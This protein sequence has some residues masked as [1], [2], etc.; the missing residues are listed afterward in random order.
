[1]LN[2]IGRNRVVLLKGFI[3]EL[4]KQAQENK[5]KRK[6]DKKKGHKLTKNKRLVELYRVG[7][8]G[9]ALSSSQGQQKF[10]K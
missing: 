4:M 1:M 6:K 5:D 7:L 9:Y 8:R 3:T 10:D 2:K